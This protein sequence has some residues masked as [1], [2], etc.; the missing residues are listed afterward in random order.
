MKPVSLFVHQPMET[1]IK[2]TN[3]LLLLIELF[4]ALHPYDHLC[5]FTYLNYVGKL[6]TFCLQF[7]YFQLLQF[8]L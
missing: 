2:L 1:A 5:L 8:K 7:R 4:Q 6:I 3:R